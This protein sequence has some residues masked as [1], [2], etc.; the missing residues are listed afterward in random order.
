MDAFKII[1]TRRSIRAYT[2][3]PISKSRIKNIV[4]C[5]RLAATA[6]NIQPWEFVVVTDKSVL[7]KI[8][9]ILPYNKFC[10]N[11]PALILV[12]CKEGDFYLEDGSAATENI[13]LAA[14]GSGLGAC[15]VAGDKQP[16]AEVLRKLLKVPKKHRLISL[17]SLGYPAEKPEKLTKR[18]ISDVLHWDKF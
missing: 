11:A 16:F 9:N 4:D 18:K 17:V 13:L 10:T 12:F 3:K 8:E 15:W 6:F 1:K 2:S 5:G 7:K 14:H